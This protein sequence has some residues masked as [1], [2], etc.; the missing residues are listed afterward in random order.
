MKLQKLFEPGK[1]GSLRIKNRLVCPP[2]ARN[3]A[4]GEGFVTQRSLDHYETLARGGVGL[5]IVEATCVESP[6]G[7]GFHYGLLLDDDRFMEGFGGLAEA[8]H[9]HGAKVAVQLHH[10]GYASPLRTTHM[11]PVGPS[12][13]TFPGYG[14]CRELH[15]AEIREIGAKF[16]S[17][18]L[19]AKKAGLDG[20][21]IHGA[22]WYLIAQFL[23]RALNRRQDQYGGTLENRARFFLEVLQSIREAVGKDFPVWARINGQEFGVPDGFPVEEA[24]VLAGMLERGGADAIHVSGRGEGDFLGYHS[25]N[26]YDPP[27]NLAHLAAAVKKQVRIPVIAV[28]K[29]SLELAEEILQ[30]G[31][32]DLVAM[33]RNLLADPELPIKAREGRIEDIRPCLGCRFCSDAAHAERRG[34]RCQ[35]NAALGREREWEVKPAETRKKIMIIGGGPAGMEAG[36]VAALRGH[37][38]WLYEKNPQLGGQMIFASAPPHKTPIREFIDYLAGQIHKGGVKIELGVEGTP[39]R[40]KALGPDVVI[41]AAGATPLIPPIEGITRKQVCQAEQVFQGVPVGEKVVVIGGGLVGCEVADYLSERGKIVTILEMLPE[42]P[43]GKCI[44]VMARLLGRL[45]KKGVEILT[46]ARCRE[47]TDTGLMFL[48]GDGEK[49]HLEAD[50]VVLAA[51]SKSNRELYDSVSSLVAE[52]YVAGDCVEPGQIRDAV[53]D[54]FQIARSI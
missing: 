17:A 12:A 51:G 30:Q 21:E 7:K 39:A 10:G 1:I 16:A 28:G 49:R 13:L 25:G 23:S 18:A 33:G 43:K 27:G 45:R 42:I 24:Q 46:G 41:L 11:Q 4:T 48:D 35:V 32:A 37:E 31:K 54:G 29:L 8:V 34:V 5:I 38:V 26:F 2:M 22:H 47:V 40:V 36:R 15:P 20:V 19:R 53:A 52:T 50:T 3:F 14:A 44:V 9:R 6:R